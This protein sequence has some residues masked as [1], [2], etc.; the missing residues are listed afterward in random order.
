M[1]R[2]EMLDALRSPNQGKSYPTLLSKTYLSQVWSVICVMICKNRPSQRDSNPTVLAKTYPSQVWSAICAMT[3]KI[4]PSQR[5]C[6]P[7]RP[8]PDGWGEYM[9]STFPPPHLNWKVVITRQSEEIIPPISGW[10]PLNFLCT[11]GTIKAF[12]ISLILL[13]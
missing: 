10:L 4:R 11:A 9:A 3:C 2:G 12:S 8:F 5:D 6:N 7:M 13:K 1:W